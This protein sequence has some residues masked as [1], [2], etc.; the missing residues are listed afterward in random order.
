MAVVATD[1]A[2]ARSQPR[3][4]WRT[5]ARRWSGPARVLAGAGG[6]AMLLRIADPAALLHALTGASA[7]WLLAA[8]AV[9][10]VSQFSV[11][12]PWGML[13]GDSR[14]GWSLV[15]RSF[16]RA[17]FVSQILPTGVGG[18][19][20]RTAEVGRVVG[21]GR[22][23]AALAGSRALGL[24]AMALWALAAAW[25]LEGSDGA[26]VV[27]LAAGFLAAVT[28]LAA[29]ALGADHVVRRAPLGRAPAA[30]R[31]ALEEASHWVRGYRARPGLL[32]LVLGVNLVGWGLNLLSMVLLANALGIHAGWALYAVAM[33]LTLAA[34]L[35]PL[36][37]N[38]LGVREGILVGLLARAGVGAAHGTAL[39][40]LVDLQYLP[41]ALVGAALWIGRGR[42]R[43]GAAPILPAC[44]GLEKGGLTAQS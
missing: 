27:A 6:L 28:A 30:V 40:V 17:N 16:L 3:R 29:L 33:P 4:G 13:I 24:V 35:V 9:G 12:V 19:A 32:A 31:R 42:V 43:T 11:A 36:T 22:A 41:L 15:S 37:V 39:A 1:L 23:L 5:L 25:M 38:G 21:Y 7:W 2:L 14:V 44:T 8:L 26:G 10:A 20:L 18:D 34:T